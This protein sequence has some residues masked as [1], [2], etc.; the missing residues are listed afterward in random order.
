M[1]A[2]AA[3]LALGA[4]AL[5]GCA[6]AAT[7]ASY[8]EQRAELATGALAPDPRDDSAPFAGAAALERAALVREVLAR[9][10]TLRA[11][12][13]A[14]EAALE[15]F[16]QATALDDPML[17][18]A[19]APQS[20]GSD[21]VDEG[22]R[23]DLSQRLPFP[24][25][26]AL[27]GR[28]A[29]A[30]AEAARG[31]LASA[32]L[33]LAALASQLYD[34]YYLQARALE[35]NTEHAALLEAFRRSA[36]A[37]YEAGEGLAQDPLRAETE[38]GHLAHDVVAARTGLRLARQQLN[39]L[40]HRAPDAPLPPPPAVLVPA[41]AGHG[42]D[43]PG[44]SIEA[45]R[46]RPELQAAEARLRARQAELDLALREFWPDLAVNGAYDRLWQDEE[47]ELRALVGVSVELP[48]QLGR[49]RAALREARARLEEARAQRDQLADELLLAL[50]SAHVQ[51]EEDRHLVDQ[52]RERFLPA[53]R[54]RVHAARASF[55][56]GRAGFP[57]LVEAERDLR[58][59]E[60]SAQQALV[61]LS[62]R[63]AEL[64][65]ATGRVPGL[66]EIAP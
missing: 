66:E 48:L 1:R 25:K 61:D 64:L 5:A 49:R 24:G 57:E 17:G 35:I 47:R 43:P 60:L 39:A 13:H 65:Q 32:R 10:P 46:V 40:L 6:G 30:E 26:R 3:A 58:R 9:N 7:Q 21:R 18:L 34:Q 23:V 8:R 31:E 12:H 51:L 14:W 29:L 11:A 52:Y 4:C 2:R 53:A 33:R 50:H 59:F 22:W 19:V 55:E 54:E 63:G 28:S 38:L 45:V 41:L 27:R 16:P 62:R 56:A 20:F 42:G 36:L 44:D 15:R 37:R